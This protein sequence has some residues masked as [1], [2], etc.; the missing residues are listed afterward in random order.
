MKS[1]IGILLTIIGI[2]IVSICCHKPADQFNL[3]GI[4]GTHFDINRF[5]KSVSTVK[6][7]AFYF[8]LLKCY[9]KEYPNSIINKSL[10]P[11]F[12]N[13][14]CYYIA[15]GKLKRFVST[16]NDSGYFTFYR[17]S[18]ETLYLFSSNHHYLVNKPE[19]DFYNPYRYSDSKKNT[20]IT[21]E[22]WEEFRK[23]RDKQCLDTIYGIQK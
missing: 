1:K 23:F 5:S 4:I 10:K 16:S 12:N 7:S 6:D 13:D 20:E 11:I 3:I 15:N 18:N 8:E 14:L 17:C 19:N 21:K 2:L 22:E 9:E